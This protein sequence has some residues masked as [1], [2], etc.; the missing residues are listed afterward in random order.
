MAL[1]LTQSYVLQ[2][3]KGLG[4]YR[5][6]MAQV[7]ALEGEPDEISG[8]LLLSL[9][10]RESGL[11][12]INNE[13]GTDRGCF[14]ISDLYHARWLGDQPG[15]PVGS[16]V[17]EKGRTALDAGYCPRYTSALVYALG[18]LQ[19]HR[20]NAHILRIPADMA[21][22]YALAAYNCGAGGALRGYQEGDVDKYTTGRDYSAWVLANRTVV[23]K[24]LHRDLRNWV[25]S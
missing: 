12:N 17:S 13:A 5:V 24:V 19:S 20:E 7:A 15:C 21:L 8:A 23:N 6:E 18:L 4:N 16:W 3:L 1:A 11:Q 10:L 22:R 25:V 9:G 2:A 14:Q